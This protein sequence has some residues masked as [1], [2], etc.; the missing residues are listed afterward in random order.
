MWISG[1]LFEQMRFSFNNL[2]H[3]VFWT[4]ELF[5][6][7][8]KRSVLKSQFQNPQNLDEK[9]LFFHHSRKKQ[10]KIHDG[11]KN[12]LNP[13]SHQLLGGIMR[14]GTNEIHTFFCKAFFKSAPV[15]LNFLV[16][17]CFKCFK[18]CLGVA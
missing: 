17:C 6:N 15:L 3:I 9:N 7:P 14:G 5:K 18:C 11:A 12:R 10:L 2:T 4:V 13:L 16:N 1:A 8:W